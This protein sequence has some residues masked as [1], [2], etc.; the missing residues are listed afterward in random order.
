[1]SV[2]SWTK[3]KGKA[4]ELSSEAASA[5]I[6]LMPPLFVYR[7][8][9]LFNQVWLGLAIGIY[10]LCHFQRLNDRCFFCFRIR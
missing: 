4:P 5:S 9:C 6:R 7:G 3:L 8:R 1:M 2:R 10:C